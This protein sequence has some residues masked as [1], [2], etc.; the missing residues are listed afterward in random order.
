MGAIDTGGQN[1]YF[2]A[3]LDSSRPFFLPRA[4][5]VVEGSL[6]CR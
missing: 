5:R 3:S 2:I 1:H 6:V 4:T